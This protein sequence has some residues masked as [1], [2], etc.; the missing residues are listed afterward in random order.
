MLGNGKFYIS[1]AV[2]N[3]IAYRTKFR[4]AERFLKKHRVNCFNPVKHEKDGKEWDYYLRRD[5]RRLTKCSA[6]VLLPDW[7]MS[8]G[9]RLEKTV[10]EALG[11][12]VVAYE[13]LVQ[14]LEERDKK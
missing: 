13:S 9:A 11:L 3:D 12:Y 14:W 4:T 7:N 2:S 5:I 1:G 10:A 8:R 6:I